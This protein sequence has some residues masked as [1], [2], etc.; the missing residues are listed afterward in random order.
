MP[1][2]RK[3][4]MPGN[5]HDDSLLHF[6]K[7]WYK[8]FLGE[9]GRKLF[10]P[11]DL[12]GNYSSV[13]RAVAREED[14]NYDPA[15]RK[16]YP[17]TETSNPLRLLSRARQLDRDTEDG[18]GIRQSID[19][20]I[21]SLIDSAK[22]AQVKN[23]VKSILESETYRD[24]L[25]EGDTHIQSALNSHYESTKHKPAY[26]ATT[27]RWDLE[28]N[29]YI[30]SKRLMRERHKEDAEALVKQLVSDAMIAK[31]NNVDP[32]NANGKTYLQVWNEKYK[33]DGVDKNSFE[34]FSPDERET[35]GQEYVYN[36]LFD[37]IFKKIST[38][39]L[40]SPDARKDFLRKY[41]KEIV[42]LGVS[43]PSEPSD[44]SPEEQQEQF[45]KSFDQAMKKLIG[46]DTPEAK[47]LKARI[48]AQA[49][50]EPI[51]SKELND[52]EKTVDAS[53]LH[54]LKE[55]DKN[56]LWSRI[57]A[58]QDEKLIEVAQR[59]RR[60]RCEK[61]LNEER[62]KLIEK[63]N[64]AERA[65][66]LF[67]LNSQVD[68]SNAGELLPDNIR[69]E[70]DPN[71]LPTLA[72]FKAALADGDIRQK[73]IKF[74][75]QRNYYIPGTDS[76]ASFRKSYIDI[77]F[78]KGDQINVHFDNALSIEQIRRDPSIR[79]ACEDLAETL[80][81]SYDQKDPVVLP[82]QRTANL[83][84]TSEAH[85]EVLVRAALMRGFKVENLKMTVKADLDNDDPKNDRVLDIERE[86][87]EAVSLAKKYQRYVDYQTENSVESLLGRVPAAIEQNASLYRDEQAYNDAMYAFE[88]IIETA[89]INKE[90]PLSEEEN[91]KFA[92]AVNRLNSIQF[93]RES[94]FT[95]A[96]NVV[97]GGLKVLPN[98]AGY[99]LTDWSAGTR[100]LFK[101][102]Q[103][104]NKPLA[105]KAIYT[106]E[107]RAK[108]YLAAKSAAKNLENEWNRIESQAPSP[109]A[110]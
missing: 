20:K 103:K 107:E 94:R 85:A 92:E 100:A 86:L 21:N 24:G 69:L 66:G 38:S 39:V 48:C 71:G 3:K 60:T 43:V 79:D 29:V 93:G 42:N 96:A 37:D 102:G 53:R 56:A 22:V 90:E 23:S 77:T 16:F 41:K 10:T 88:Q 2:K 78:G 75:F 18:S 30:A 49:L 87:G 81:S 70:N 104:D 95:Q 72:D 101:T 35:L 83:F 50:L 99:F 110:R 17:G 97:T 19:K 7:S 8:Y 34:D 51:H 57:V 58:Q 59:I 91:G 105:V 73:G 68:P 98:S 9:E 106:P 14:P 27:G 5:A 74:R 61:I 25:K 64:E 4:N 33:T 45:N 36:E 6:P 31:Q 55:H 108:I 89:Q 80:W 15:T 65:G 63:N 82:S 13:N 62:Q 44:N 52:L 47:S 1:Y 46:L 12:Y 11:N 28:K 40:S 32:N 54:Y 67:S 109:A 76:V 26:A 84:A